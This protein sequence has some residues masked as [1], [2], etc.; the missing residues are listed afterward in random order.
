MQLDVI[1]SFVK[2]DIDNVDVIIAD[3]LGS[4]IS[5][6]RQLGEHIFGSGGKR[7]RPTLVVL[8]SRVFNYQG[9][10]HYLLAAIVELI[11]TATLLHDDVV[12]DSG[13]RRGQ[14]TANRIWGNDA[15]VLVGDFLYSRAFQM[16]VEVGNLPVLG[17]LA[18]AAN[19]IAEGEVMQLINCN[20]PGTSEERYMEVIRRKTATLFEAS[21][22]LGAIIC[23]RS[24]DEVDAMANYGLYVGLAFQLIDDALDYGASQQ[25][26]GKNIGDDLAEG[27]A[28]L[29]LIHA[30]RHCN[31]GD[32]ELISQAVAAASLEN[33]QAIRDVIVNTG[34]LEYTY[35]VARKH[36]ELAKQCIQEIPDSEAKT[37]LI[38]FAEFAVSR[39]F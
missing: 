1:R 9:T 14:R 21:A 6:I 27:K 24:P 10:E 32:R 37:I 13:Q 35:Q 4:E 18:N 38:D 22:Q 39:Q 29:P 31:A 8:G 33:L 11:H 34:A 12:D 3:R 19:T 36:A 7:L 5:M 20:D 28:T 16:M 2:E 30:L 25:D 23:K 26:I 17:V 15:S